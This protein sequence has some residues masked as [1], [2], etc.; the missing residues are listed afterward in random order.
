MK[1]IITVIILVLS[2]VAIAKASTNKDTS[3]VET[4]ITLQT[5][6]GNLFGTLTTPEKFDKIPVALIIAGSGPTDRDGNNSMMKNDSYKILAKELAQNGIATLRYDKRGIGESKGAAK[7]E[8]DLRFEDYVNDAEDW[9]VL[10][11][12]DKRFSKVVII[13]HSEGS[14]IGMLA[15]KHADQYISLAGAG[16]TIDKVLKIQLAPQP[17]QVKNIAFPILDT[18]KMG[19]IVENVP[20][21]LYSLFRPS[22]QPY[23]ISWFKYDPQ[24]VI[25]KLTIPILII[26]GTNDLQIGVDEAERLSKANPKSKLVLIKNMNHV[27]RIIDGDKQANMASYNN[28]ELPIAEELV[29][30]ITDFILKK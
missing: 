7:A 17:E 18:L 9:I 12:D 30:N 25:K 10:L 4:K 6:T 19:K 15:A 28:S 29:K 3:I 11:K 21:M 23:L 13:G 5:K 1:K 26:Q 16:Q 22:V 14:L 8:A 27:F 2:N 20:P 24:E